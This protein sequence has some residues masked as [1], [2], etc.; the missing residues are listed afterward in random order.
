MSGSV[1]P[2]F[3]LSTEAICTQTDLAILKDG[4]RS[5]PS[6]H[7]SLSFAGLGFLAFYLGKFN[8]L[9]SSHPVYLS[10]FS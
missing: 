4:F 8:V 3:G 7:S 6:G 5:F 2:I 1:D 9:M 10:S